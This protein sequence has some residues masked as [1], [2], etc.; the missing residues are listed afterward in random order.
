MVSCE[1]TITKPQWRMAF[2]LKTLCTRAL[3]FL[4]PPLCLSCDAPVADRATLCPECWKKIQ[5]ITPPFCAC[6]G[7]AFDIPV[8]VTTLCGACIADAPHF[9]S[10]RGAII[11]DDASR[12]I[13]LGFKHGDRTENLAALAGWMQRA[14]GEI[15]ANCDILIPVPLHRWRLLQRHY[16]QS[17][18]LAQRLARMT[19]KIYIANILQRIRN[20]PSQGHRKRKER[21]ENVKGAFTVPN[22]KRDLIAGKKIILIDDV[23]TTGA[24]VDECARILLKAGAAEVHVLTLSRVK[25]YV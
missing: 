13:V 18:L 11:Y 3:D 25:S 20:T 7:A 2:L 4:L 1:V 24:T 10:V 14:G 22:E 8:D 17:A 5:F 9:Q 16:N 23:M 6:C 21:Q 19:N 12:K 15:L